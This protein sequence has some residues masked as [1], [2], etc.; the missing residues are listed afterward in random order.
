MNSFFKERDLEKGFWR[1]GMSPLTVN[2][3]W[4]HSGK[5]Q[6]HGGGSSKA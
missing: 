6:G 3:K 1:K 2:V 4:N 5:K